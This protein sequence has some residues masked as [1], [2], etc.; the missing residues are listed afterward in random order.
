MADAARCSIARPAGIP[1]RSAGVASGTGKTLQE[2]RNFPPSLPK[3][4]EK[5]R[6]SGV[7]V[8]VRDGALKADGNVRNAS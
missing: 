6:V 4:K 1:D 2:G 5:P 8:F 3:L 7:F